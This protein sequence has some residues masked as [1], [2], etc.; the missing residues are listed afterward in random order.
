MVGSDAQILAFTLPS[1]GLFGFR[2]RVR[3]RLWQTCTGKPP[4]GFYL[5]KGGK[6]L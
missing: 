5:Q 6:K 2:I 3:A 1:L 4:V